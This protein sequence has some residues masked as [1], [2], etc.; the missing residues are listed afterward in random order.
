LRN[1]NKVIS[2]NFGEETFSTEPFFQKLQFDPY[3]SQK[4]AKF[5]QEGPEYGKLK[6][7]EKKLRKIL[8]DEN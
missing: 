2:D 5:A 6:F 8:T 1:K 7:S 4:T 3:F